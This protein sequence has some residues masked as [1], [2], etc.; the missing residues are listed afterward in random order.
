M[1]RVCIPSRV[2]LSLPS[3]CTFILRKDCSCPSPRKRLRGGGG[4]HAQQRAVNALTWTQ[5][6]VAPAAAR[7][8]QRVPAPRGCRRPQAAPRRSLAISP[9][10]LEIRASFN[11]REAGP[12]WRLRARNQRRWTVATCPTPIFPKSGKPLDSLS[13]RSREKL[14]APS[15]DAPPH[16]HATRARGMR[17][18]PCGSLHPALCIRRAER[19][20]HDRDREGCRYH[21]QDHSSDAFDRVSKRGLRLGRGTFA[22]GAC[23][24]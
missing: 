22:C 2:G 12:R 14:H 1:Q 6:E 11:R 3:P 7:L 24:A 23:L 17:L 15:T 21:D 10:S 8:R 20:L 5:A 13:C 18:L 4:S 9:S 16:S 19:A